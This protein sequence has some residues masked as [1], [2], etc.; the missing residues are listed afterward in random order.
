MSRVFGQHKLHKFY[1][2][3]GPYGQ[4]EYNISVGLSDKGS[5]FIFP[6]II[7]VEGH[8]KIL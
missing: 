1:L 5:R 8:F 7:Q 3:M 6:C 4:T 2:T